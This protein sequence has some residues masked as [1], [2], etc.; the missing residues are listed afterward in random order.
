MLAKPAARPPSG[1]SAAA[2]GGKI[3]VVTPIPFAMANAPTSGMLERL[4]A[5]AAQGGGAAGLDPKAVQALVALTAEVVE[6]VVWEVV[7]EMA[8]ALIREKANQ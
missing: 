6:Q 5:A 7:P 3:P 4:K 8:E 2:S 1:P